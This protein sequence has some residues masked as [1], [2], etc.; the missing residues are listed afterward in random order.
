MLRFAVTFI[1]LALAGPAL[2]VSPI[3]EV[4]CSPRDEMVKTLRQQFGE[5]QTGLGTRGPETV[6]EVWTSPRSGDWTLVMT[7]ADGR[8]CIVA[9]GE[10]WQQMTLGE[11]PA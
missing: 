10:N 2:A 6:M 7:Y 8:S 3:A 11:D 9:M 1:S 4:V 5:Q